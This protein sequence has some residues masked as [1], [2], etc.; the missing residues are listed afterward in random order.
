M[1]IELL[2]ESHK[3]IIINYSPVFGELEMFPHDLA[4]VITRQVSVSVLR[5]NNH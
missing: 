5:E 3:F 1:K 4:G 2:F